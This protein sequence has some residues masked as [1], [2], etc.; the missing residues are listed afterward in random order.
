MAIAKK[1]L[2]YLAKNKIKYELIEHRTVF[3]AF[4]AACTQKIKPQLIVKTLVIKADNK[5]LLALTPANKNLD[6]QKLKKITKAKKI[7]FAKEAWMKKNL[8][9]KVGA[10]PSFGKLLDLP[11]YLDKT[12]MK[13]K[14]LYL[15]TGDYTFSFKIKTTAF[16]K[17]EEPIIGVFSKVKK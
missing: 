10:T 11:V 14:E 15:N 6:L 2:N 13:N 12:L 4:D 3:T 1:I 5:I 8:I 17:L 16:I 9:G 7:A